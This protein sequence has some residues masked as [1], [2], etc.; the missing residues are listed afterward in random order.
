MSILSLWTVSVIWYDNCQKSIKIAHVDSNKDLYIFL[1]NPHN[2]REPL[3]EE[4]FMNIYM[5]KNVFVCYFM[6]ENLIRNKTMK[7][8][9]GVYH[10]TARTPV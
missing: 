3:N 6:Q 9:L 2:Q 7:C 4:Q 5:H 10:I 1:V 8:K